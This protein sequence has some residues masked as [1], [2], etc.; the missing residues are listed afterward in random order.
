M[1]QRAKF[2]SIFDEIHKNKTLEIPLEIRVKG[3][4]KKKKRERGKTWGNTLLIDPIVKVQE[5]NIKGLTSF[6]KKESE[7]EKGRKRE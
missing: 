2:W 5:P 1:D 7:R 6:G 4:G 3:G